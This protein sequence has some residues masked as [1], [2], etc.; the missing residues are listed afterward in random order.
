GSVEHHRRREWSHRHP[1]V[2]FDHRRRSN[3]DRGVET[4]HSMDRNHDIDRWKSGAC[5]NETTVEPMLL[6]AQREVQGELV[7]DGLVADLIGARPADRNNLASGHDDQPD[8]AHRVVT[9]GP[10]RFDELQGE[11][12]LDFVCRED[13]AQA[14]RKTS[15]LKGGT[16]IEAICH[17]VG[18][19]RRGYDDVEEEQDRYRDAKSVQHKPTPRVCG[20]RL[21]QRR[22]TTLS[23]ARTKINCRIKLVS[24]GAAPYLPENCRTRSSGRTAC[25]RSTIP[26]GA[27]AVG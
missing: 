9:E 27:A 13:R 4:S 22:D 24:V 10:V 18:G 8:F 26:R 20:A 1:T 19:S 11:R 6:V 2:P 14:R 23:R 21:N 7:T 15:P 3:R 17:G 5:W 12:T 16:W 25:T